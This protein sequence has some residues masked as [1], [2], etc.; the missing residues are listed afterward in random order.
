MPAGVR[1]S[2]RAFAVG[3]FQENAYLVADADARRAVLVDP[4]DEADRLLL[5]VA[6]AGSQLQAI[7][8]THAHVDHV[9]A[10]A[11]IKRRADVPIYLHPLERPLYQ[12]AAQHGLLFG[13]RI[14]PPPPA[15]RELADGDTLTV[16]EL[17]FGVVHVPGHA[18]GHV[19][20]HGH[21]IAFVGDCL[22]AG[23]IG[24]T[25]LPL[26][27]GAE[28]ARSLARICELPDDTVVYP[29]HGPATT[30]GEERVTN[31]FLNGTLR[32]VGS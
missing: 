30:I 19:V 22:F 12:N 9:G 23:S 16:G 10:I 17:S 15:D 7:W 24:R 14:E 1:P 18:P 11:A 28:L 29:G 8:L 32:V 26:A 5:A 6:E 25:D 27:N 21:G 20:I 3:P 2:V 13:M 4:G 31:P